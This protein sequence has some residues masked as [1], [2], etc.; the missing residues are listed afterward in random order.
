MERRR[1]VGWLILGNTRS[2][3]IDIIYDDSEMLYENN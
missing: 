1:I 3:L 2:S